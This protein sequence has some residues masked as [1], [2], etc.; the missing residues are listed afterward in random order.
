MA[1][2]VSSDDVSVFKLQR[3][4]GINESP[5][6][7]TQLKMGEGSEMRN[8]QVTPQ[9]HL[10][11]RPGCK[12]VHQFK[13]PVRG[14]WTGYVA[15][16]KK[17]VC[18]AD[19]GVWELS[20]D[21]I[22]RIGDIWDAPTTMFSFGNKVYFLN[23][24]EYLVWDG[25]GYV[26]TVDGYIPL[27][28]SGVAP[29]GGGAQVENANRLT[30]KRRCQFSSDGK[31]T[32][33]HLPEKGMLTIDKITIGTEEAYSG[34]AADLETGVITFEAA[35]EAGN[36]NVGVWYTMPNNLRS[37]IEG[38]RYA[39][40]FNGA[41]DTRV[42]LYGDGTAKAVYCGV[43]ENGQAS[44]EYFPDLYEVLI[45][46]ENS[47]LTGM[48]KYYDRLMSYKSDG[49]AYST[50]YEVTTL[51]DGTVIPG[52]KTVSTNKE[53]GN[54][55]IGQV[56]LVK[57]TPRTIYGGNVYDWVYANYAT[58][59][60]RNAK[61]VSAR[62]QDTM[63]AA[64]PDKIFCFDDDSKQEYYIFLNDA[65]GTALVHNYMTDIWYIYTN[66][67]VTCAGRTEDGALLFGMND[68][69]LAIFSEDNPNDDGTPID[70]F[71]A[72]GN[73]AFGEEYKRKHSSAIWVSVKPTSNAN[74][75]VTARTDRKSDYVDKEVTMN[76]STF[77][78]L[79]FGS[80]SFMTTRAPQMERIKLKVKKFAYYQLILKSDFMA[81]DATVLGV[82]FR[83]RYTGYVK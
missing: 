45:G 10:R 28:S 72:S 4:L 71:F 16:E 58:R 79:N 80:F 57:N 9:Y 63:S 78:G 1:N 15:G 43:T 74:L 47:P 70:A 23:G 67:P 56:R 12:T 19:G 76:L 34:W 17:T 61:I 83:V 22:R 82:D 49:G 18:A 39:E 68:G 77:K 3:F 75:I 60:E 55:A 69:R 51:A 24:H 66:L 44:A 32:E 52:F 62:V 38:M 46:S 6:G 59:D 53:I 27:V 40:Q 2:I 13:N 31:A 41:A 50:S 64:D 42:F 29:G 30:G 11:V 5:D 7:D 20:K 48:I 14:I 35:P 54:E 36:N 26:D 65:V 25:D 33:Y 37:L 73:M 21:P 8:W 81:S